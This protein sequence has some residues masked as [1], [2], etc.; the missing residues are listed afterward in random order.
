MPGADSASTLELLGAGGFGF[1]IGWY[2]YYV[3]RYRGGNVQIA[4]LVT[5]IG[6]LGGGAV[7]DLFP[8]QSEL[9]GA[10]GIG[11]FIGFFSYLLVLVVL[12]ARSPKFGVE[13]FLDG[14]RHTLDANEYIPDTGER[15][16]G[17][18]GGGVLP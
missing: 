5:V 17:D 11:L 7:L 12:V 1:V 14:R 9:F 2:L 15:A 13:W 10:Y 18:E 6:A 3:N 16:M 8:A 4:D